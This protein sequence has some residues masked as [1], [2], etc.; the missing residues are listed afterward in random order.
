VLGIFKQRIT[1]Q[2]LASLVLF[3]ILQADDTE[4][5]A[6]LDAI[7]ASKRLIAQRE[8]LLVRWHASRL[9][10]INQY[11]K[12]RPT[13]ERLFAQMNVFAEVLTTGV[14]AEYDVQQAQ[15]MWTNA[16]S[17]LNARLLELQQVSPA[18]AER[19]VQA[20]QWAPEPQYVQR[21]LDE[22]SRAF[23][24]GMGRVQDGFQE[25]AGELSRRLFGDVLI[26]AQML[27]YMVIG[28]Q[29]KAV[30]ELVGGLKII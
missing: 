13:C 1:S 11:G 25:M 27:G 26:Q 21:R 16:Q 5:I 10:L 8:L 30:S 7:G 19:I 23:D 17:Y 9:A 22:Y 15:S 12:D 4:A 24:R 3:S 6:S 28:E 2:D 18:K 29:W 20:K 14:P